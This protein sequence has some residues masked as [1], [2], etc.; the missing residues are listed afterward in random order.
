M[1][2]QASPQTVMESCVVLFGFGDAT[3]NAHTYGHLG[4]EVEVG[5]VR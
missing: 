5:F 3:K 2:Y 4:F 1:D